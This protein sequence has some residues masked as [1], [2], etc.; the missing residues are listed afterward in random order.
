MLAHGYSLD[1]KHTD[2]SLIFETAS[3][4]RFLTCIHDP[5]VC[6]EQNY[7]KNL[8]SYSC[9]KISVYCMDMYVFEVHVLSKMIYESIV[10]SQISHHGEKLLVPIFHI[11]ENDVPLGNNRFCL[12]RI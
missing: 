4:M 6:I 2:L 12:M 1:P 8:F 11:W 10:E 9:V 3:P 5:H 7:K